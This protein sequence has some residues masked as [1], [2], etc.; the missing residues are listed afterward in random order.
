MKNQKRNQGFTLIEVLIAM[1][2]FALGFLSIATMQIRYI[3]LSTTARVQTEATQAAVDSL[4]RLIALP[5]DHTDLDE[6]K[7]PHR[8]TA[9]GYTIEWTVKGDFPINSSKTI[10]I[11][12][13]AAS[14]NSKPICI[15][16]V[17]AQRS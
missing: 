1:A 4:E 14:P 11:R 6:L 16:F 12:V 17:K 10:A 3:T 13:N 9:D 2:I 15:N 5:Y 8:L 7:N